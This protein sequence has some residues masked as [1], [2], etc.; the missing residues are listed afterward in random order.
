MANKDKHSGHVRDGLDWYVEPYWCVDALLNVLRLPENTTVWD[1]ACG[2]GTV[3]E[4]CIA[5]GLAAYG[6]DICDR[7]Y[8]IG[9]GDFL[10]PQPCPSGM[11]DAII[12]NPPYSKA[13]KFS[14]QALS[15]TNRYSALLVRL[16]FL[17]SIQRY[18][19]FTS[20]PPARVLVF[21]KR[22][23]MPPGQALQDG[24]AKRVGGQ[25]DFCWIV[26]DKQ[27][28]GPAQIQWLNPDLGDV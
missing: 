22:P 4:R 14:Q 20:M 6:S 3:P 25:H 17:A 28:D 9:T 21:S 1:P 13:V 12:T 26:W 11:P 8:G 16:D 7:G 10:S 24:T 27:H 2:M 19:I 23:S 18:T 15:L 5:H